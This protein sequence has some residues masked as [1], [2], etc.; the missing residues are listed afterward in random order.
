MKDEIAK[1]LKLNRDLDKYIERGISEGLPVKIGWG[2]AGDERPKNG[3]IGVI[4]HLPKKSKVICLG[5]LGECSGSMN[6]GGTFT[7]KGSAASM[8]G[9]FHESGRTI[10]ERDCGQRVGYMMKGGEVTIHGSVGDEA[11]SGMSGGT[12][13]I[14]GQ[15]GNRVGMGMTGGAILVMGSVGSE[16]CLG[17]TGGKAIVCGSCPPP[18]DEVKI[19]SIETEEILEFSPFVDP[20]GV[21][22]NE[23]ALVIEPSSKPSIQSSKPPSSIKT[24]FENVALFPSGT[25]IPD[26]RPVAFH[27]VL[28][29]D[30]ENDGGILLP[31]PWIVSTENTKKWKGSF[32]GSQPAMVTENPRENDLLLVGVDNIAKCIEFIG[33][34]GG[35]VIDSSEFSDLNDAEIEGLI[36][37]LTSRIP[38]SSVVMVRGGFERVDEIFRIIMDLDID[39]AIIDGSSPNGTKLVSVLPTIGIAAKNI[40]LRDSGKYVLI[41]FDKQPSAKDLL[42]CLASGSNSVIAPFNENIEKT[43]SE[44]STELGGWMR[45]IGIENIE[46]IGRRNLRAMD[47]ETAAISGLRLVGYDRPLPIW[48]DSR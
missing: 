22:I 37:S 13:V 18:S 17:M 3:E 41:E 4:T 21:S 35:I 42:I 47:Y 28:E 45:Q 31:M 7:L 29:R 15:A 11:G 14:R 34:C 26:H 23:D 32:S 19:R 44:M 46:R 38:E 30:S 43:L 6:R 27:S 8:F 25:E 5:N 1:S 40:G 36:V 12:I 10:V 20:L 16:P 48:L 2:Q 24:Y 9:S 39:G 33:S